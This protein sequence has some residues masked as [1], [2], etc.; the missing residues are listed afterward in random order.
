MQNPELKF[1]VEWS[2]R[3]VCENC[4]EMPE[5]LTE[6]L[7]QH[8]IDTPPRLSHDSRSAKF[9]SYAVDVMLESREEMDA[10]GKT[11]AHIPGVRLVL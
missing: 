9:R 8:H 3:I 4:P 6:A 10:I 1:P 11:L 5:R 2:Y 7:R